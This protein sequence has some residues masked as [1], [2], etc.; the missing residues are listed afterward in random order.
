M[1]HD[2]KSFPLR[3]HADFKAWVLQEPNAARL[4]K[5]IIYRWRGSSARVRGNPPPEG[6]KLVRLRRFLSRRVARNEI[7]GN[8]LLL[9]KLPAG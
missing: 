9:G 1:T 5:E 2:P 6:H 3:D 7:N 4:L 8:C